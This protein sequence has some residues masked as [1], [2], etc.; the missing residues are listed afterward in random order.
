M[1]YGFLF[2]F[3]VEDTGTHG[4]VGSPKSLLR[5]PI[6]SDLQENTINQTWLCPQEN[7]INGHREETSTF[8]KRSVISLGFLQTLG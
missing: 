3:F 1:E 8:Q 2:I 7:P 5:S 6:L 4:R